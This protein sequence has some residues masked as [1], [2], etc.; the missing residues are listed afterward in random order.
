MSK[1]PRYRLECA[2]GYRRVLPGETLPR[3]YSWWDRRVKDWELGYNCGGQ[4]YDP[5]EHGPIAV[6]D[7]PK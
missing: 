6:K 5:K 3:E 7:E 2:K 1:E 4:P